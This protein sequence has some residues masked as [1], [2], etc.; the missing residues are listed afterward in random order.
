M[1]YHEAAIEHKRTVEMEEHLSNFFHTLYLKAL[2]RYRHIAYIINPSRSELHYS[3]D[4]RSDMWNYEMKKGIEDVSWRFR[5]YFILKQI[6]HLL[7]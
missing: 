4:I 6:E 1:H 2:E 5:Y 3:V 7:N